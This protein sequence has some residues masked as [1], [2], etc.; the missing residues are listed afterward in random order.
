MKA[1]TKFKSLVGQRR[2]IPKP[3]TP[4]PKNLGAQGEVEGEERKPTDSRALSSKEAPEVVNDE[5]KAKKAAAEHAAHIIRERERFLKTSSTAA[6]G[7]PS[8]QPSPGEKGHAHDVT[9]VEAPFLGIGT[10]DQDAFAS[11]DIHAAEV[12]SDS[13]TAVH[14]DVFDKAFEEEVEKIKRSTSRKGRRG[15][16]LYLTRHLRDEKKFKTMEDPEI[17]WVGEDDGEDDERGASGTSNVVAKF[18]LS[19]PS[20][21][22]TFANMVAGAVK[23]AK[24]KAQE[25]VGGH[26]DGSEPD[27]RAAET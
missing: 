10:G 17:H 26:Q 7:P 14:F 24:S 25:A 16:T 27:S 2:E 5:D 12:L 15:T 6:S 20:S 9:D 19:A 21:G 18:M 11:G 23:G 4:T 13:P 8:R 22:P 1:I 3:K